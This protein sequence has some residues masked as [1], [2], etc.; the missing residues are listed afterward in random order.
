MNQFELFC[1]V[2]YVLDAEWD[3]S[4]DAQLGDF[5]SRANPFLFEVL[6]ISLDNISIQFI[7]ASMISLSNLLGK[8]N[9]M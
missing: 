2:Y 1:M 5:L 8:S 6:R 3:E 4:K 9:L 7:R